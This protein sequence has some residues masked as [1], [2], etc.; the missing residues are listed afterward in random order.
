[1]KRFLD[2]NFTNYFGFGDTNTKLDK[3]IKNQFDVPGK[4][5]TFR[6]VFFNRKFHEL[7][8]IKNYIFFVAIEPIY[9]LQI[10]TFSQ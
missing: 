1:M 10:A 6:G 9:N 3:I 2:T 8:Q 5:E 7:A 4:A